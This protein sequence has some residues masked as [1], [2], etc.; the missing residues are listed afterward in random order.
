MPP[1]A[2]K[3]EEAA[4]LLAVLGNIGKSVHPPDYLDNTVAELARTGTAVIDELYPPVG[5]RGRR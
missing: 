3:A 4:V 5:R 1:P 2:Q